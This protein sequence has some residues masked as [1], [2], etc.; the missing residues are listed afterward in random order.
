MV[1]RREVWERDK[2]LAKSL[3]DAFIRSNAM[4]AAAQR[5]FPYVSPWLDCELEETEAL[6]GADFHQDGYERNRPT[7]EAFCQQ[8]FDLGITRRRIT[9][10]DYFAEFLES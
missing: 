3:T 8:A 6:M 9:A 4:F 7:I 5:N 10:E 2:W 1:I